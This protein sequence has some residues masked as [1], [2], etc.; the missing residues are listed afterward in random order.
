MGLRDCS[1]EVSSH[2]T[3]V[4]PI[5]FKFSFAN[6]SWPDYT[7]PAPKGVPTMSPISGSIPRSYHSS[8]PASTVPNSSSIPSPS[9]TSIQNPSPAVS[10]FDSRKSVPTP[11]AGWTQQNSRHVSDSH[12]V[13]SSNGEAPLINLL[14]SE[15]AIAL[16]TSTSSVPKSLNVTSH[17]KMNDHGQDSPVMNETLS[18]IQEHISDMSTPRHS[19]SVDRRGLNDSGSEYSS[20]PDHRISYIN[21]EETD[22]DEDED[23]NNEADVRSWTPIQVAD[24]LASV[25]IDPTHC[26][27]FREQEISGEVLLEMEQSSL[28][29]PIF[30]LGSIGKRLKIWQ[31]IKAL[32]Q[33]VVG[34]PAG[35][36]R[37]TQS[38]GS[39]V[40][41]EDIGRNRSQSQSQI[42]RGSTDAARVPSLMEGRDS[43][44]NRYSQ[45][46]GV[47]SNSIQ[48]SSPISSAP[49]TEQSHTMDSPTRPSAASIRDLHHSRRHSSKDYGGSSFS[50]TLPVGT[51]SPTESHSPA[52]HKKERS[53][54][55]N[56][57]MGNQ[58]PVVSVRPASSHG[59]SALT[60]ADDEDSITGVHLTTPWEF[61]RGYFSGGEA[62][63]R[64]RNV[65]RKKPASTHSRNSSYTD[66]QRARTGTTNARHSRYGSVDSI[67]QPH[68]SSASQKYYNLPPGRRR[69]PS[70]SSG[71]T[72][73]SPKDVSSPAVTKLD[74]NNAKF[75]AGSPTS[76]PKPNTPDWLQPGNG[77]SSP[78]GFGLRAISDT[79]S[80]HEK[81]R[82]APPADS[83]PS[84]LKDDSLQSPSR[85]GST[86]SGGP[87]LELEPTSNSKAPSA[88]NTPSS[89]KP[90]KKTK[91]ET[92]AYLR[93]LE[94][95]APREQMKDCDYSGWMKKKSTNL[96]TTWKPRLFILKGKRLSYYYSEDDT[97]EKGLIDIS[98]H[99]V[100]PADHDVITGLHAQITRATQSPTSPSNS[101]TTTMAAKDAAAEAQS[102]L[103]KSV[104]DSMFI[105]KLVPPKTGLSQAITFTKPTVHYFAV[106]NITQG[107]LW[108]AAL[109]KATIERDYTQK[110]V[111]TFQAKT[112]SL[113]TARA[114][115]HRP[116]AL[117]NLEEKAE[118]EP[119]KTPV[120][121]LNG[122]NIRGIIFDQDNKNEKDSGMS[123][124][125]RSDPVQN[126]EISKQPESA[127]SYGT[128]PRILDTTLE[129]G[130]LG[131]EEELPQTA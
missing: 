69:T 98:F 7:R 102:S 24:Y 12:V 16:P 6:C 111:S 45:Q 36:R 81:A 91:K 38:Y 50:T 10:T 46:Q 112:I 121:D 76:Q 78:R 27:V 39:E 116:P 109:M 115:R 14:S 74:G 3:Y 119:V 13:G 51:D 97:Q 29:V 49:M 103:S 104:G 72:L 21:G 44:S 2:A 100:L 79:V 95:K 117:M 96:M 42:S 40:G 30:D 62:D 83:T 89:G 125:S 75:T 108:M 118:E 92:S 88:K 80:G 8:M 57:S 47:R 131:G 59:D 93:G 1:Q 63:G 82:V 99:K 114:Q 5:F 56:W 53:F 37:N 85:T 64:L 26:E 123:D 60:N 23:L 101:Q 126:I 33:E 128:F 32:Q 106:P 48:A 54:D 86:T 65:L 61:D 87:S 43:R 105:F 58:S 67:S 129:N 19:G 77:I 110:I 90:K 52:T 20:Y 22:E 84:P 70:M 66:E 28:L 18:V 130:A 15:N 41:S 94:K 35:T 68:M 4:L 71:G 34:T 113:A 124:K 9:S 127:Q 31:K 73:V 107:R 11:E 120:I 25:G 122:L 17:T 55:R